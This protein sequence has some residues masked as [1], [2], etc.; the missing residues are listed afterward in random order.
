M[1]L[2]GDLWSV[3]YGV[4]QHLHG[5]SRNRLI[6]DT[7]VAPGAPGPDDRAD[8]LAEKLKVKRAKAEDQAAT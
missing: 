8:E 5:E 3:D 1:I 6:V 2:N 7:E 4:I